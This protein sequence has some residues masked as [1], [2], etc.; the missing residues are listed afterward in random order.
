MSESQTAFGAPVPVSRLH[1]VSSASPREVSD[2]VESLQI[3]LASLRICMVI[4][5]GSKI[6]ALTMDLPGGLL[7][8]GALRAKVNCAV[9]GVIIAKGGEFQGSLEADEVIVEG[10]ITSPLDASGRPLP[11]TMSLIT[12]RG[13]LIDGGEVAGGLMSLSAH[14]QV[15]AKLRA[16]SYSIPRTADLSRSIMETLAPGN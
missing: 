5:A 16:V 7:V 2:A 4:P 14:A 1:P 13:H 10:K 8:L 15:C 12:A 6:D 3:S 9:G 11:S